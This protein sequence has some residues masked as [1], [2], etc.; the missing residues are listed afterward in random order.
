MKLT[1]RSFLRNDDHYSCEQ[2][3]ISWMRTT[4]CLLQQSNSQIKI[5]IKS[6]SLWCSD[7]LKHTWE[8]NSKFS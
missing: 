1:Q 6:C 8:N 7:P 2:H 5:K 4:Q 3:Q